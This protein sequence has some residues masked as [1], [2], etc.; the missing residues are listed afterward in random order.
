MRLRRRRGGLRSASGMM[1]PRIGQ[2]SGGACL[3][4]S[5]WAFLMAATR[6]A[7]RGS[8]HSLRAMLV[9]P[10]GGPQPPG[11]SVGLGFDWTMIGPSS[12]PCRHFAATVSERGPRPGMEPTKA[13][14]DHFLPARR[15]SAPNGQGLQ[16][17]RNEEI[18]QVRG[19]PFASTPRMAAGSNL[20]CTSRAASLTTTHTPS[21]LL[22]SCRSLSLVTGS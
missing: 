12:F 2:L 21:T 15:T 5:A 13:I 3:G 19:L 4:F 8:I 18:S 20:G 16:W 1:N 10:S 6:S 22:T 11:Q 17:M 9:L 7:Y 14:P